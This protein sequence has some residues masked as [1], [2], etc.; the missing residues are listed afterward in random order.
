MFEGCFESYRRTNYVGLGIFLGLT[1]KAGGLSEEP[2]EL[3]LPS[4]FAYGAAGDRTPCR[5]DLTVRTARQH[6]SGSFTRS[7]LAAA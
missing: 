1:V 4:A 6:L 7:L 3:P 2:S 5:T